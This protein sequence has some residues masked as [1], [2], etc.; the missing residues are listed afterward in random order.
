MEPWL[1]CLVLIFSFFD[2]SYNSLQRGGL[3]NLLCLCFLK[4]RIGPDISVLPFI[5]RHCLWTRTI[6]WP[7]TIVATVF[8]RI[9]YPV[10]QHL[11]ADKAITIFW[12]CFAVHT[13][14]FVYLRFEILHDQ[15]NVELGLDVSTEI[16]DNRRHVYT[17]ILWVEKFADC[18]SCCSWNSYR[19]RIVS[20][21]HSNM[22][23]GPLN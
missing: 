1:S 4:I 14:C 11:I 21:F 18:L 8:T 10:S 20:L 5:E 2:V 17:S 19:C 16:I 12:H 13:R 23:C 3:F 7:C 9:E 15:T 6:L 22:N